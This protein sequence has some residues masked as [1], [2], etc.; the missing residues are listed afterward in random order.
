MARETLVGTDSISFQFANS[1][2]FA[3]D[4]PERLKRGNIYRRIR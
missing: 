4:E 2:V 3:Y 1:L